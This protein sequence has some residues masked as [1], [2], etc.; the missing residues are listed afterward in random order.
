[1]DGSGNVLLVLDLP[2]LIRYHLAQ[3]HNTAQIVAPPVGVPSLTVE[4]RQP[5][6]VLVAD[7]SVY[8]RQS[9]RQTFERVGYQ[10]IEARDGVEAL[11]CLSSDTPP[12][13]LLLDI[14]MPNLNGY[15]LLNILHAQPGIAHCKTILLTSRSSEKHR[16]RAMELGAYAFLSKPCPQE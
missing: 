4:G 13:V 3:R 1:V 10:V 8:I 11:E 9:L 6:T 7:D 5:V 12:S 14:E 15:D 16:Q 2:M